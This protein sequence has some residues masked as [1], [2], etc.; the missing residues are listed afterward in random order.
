MTYLERTYLAALIVTIAVYAWYFT[1]VFTNLPTDMNS[2]NEF[3]TKLWTMMGAYVVLVIIISILA[4]ILQKEPAEEFDERDDIIDMKAERIASYV[5]A[6]A[7]FGILVL[8][9]FDFSKFILA[10]A[11]LATM[12]LSTIISVSV[13]L[14]LY[15]RG[16]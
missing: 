15:K 8:V 3:G 2:T 9:M 4:N 16:V 5:Q 10:H 14:Y 11:L 6:V 13:R 1:S 7:V 12:V